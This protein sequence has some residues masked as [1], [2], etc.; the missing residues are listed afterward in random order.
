MN[1]DDPK[2]T[3]YALDELDPAERAEI[4]QMLAANPDARAEIEH[5]RSFAEKLRSEL[6]AEVAEALN[7]EQRELVLSE[8]SGSVLPAPALAERPFWR[9][10]GVI[11][12]IAASIVAA[13]PG[14]RFSRRR[15]GTGRVRWQLALS[16]QVRSLR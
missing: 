12:A 8:K 5:T 6:R 1:H 10:S 14:R 11:S 7:D 15:S 16:P 2:L 4:E 13:Q 3:A 9:R